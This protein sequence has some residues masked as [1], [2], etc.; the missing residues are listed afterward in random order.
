M[1]WHVLKLQCN[2]FSLH[3]VPKLLFAFIWDVIFP[4]I[5]RGQR[6]IDRQH[7]GDRLGAH[8]RDF[9]AVRTRLQAQIFECSV[10]LPCR[11][12]CDSTFVS[13]VI[14]V[15]IC[16]DQRPVELQIEAQQDRIWRFQPITNL[17]AQIKCSFAFVYAT[18]C[19]DVA[20]LLCCSL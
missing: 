8:S 17:A 9:G 5:H 16:A 11:T 12:D 15:Q 1:A 20:F 14:G 10:A 4:Q 3:C 19:L 7:F 18:E 2:V 13:N 6:P